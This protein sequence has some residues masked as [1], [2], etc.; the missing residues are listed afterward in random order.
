MRNDLGTVGAFRKADLRAAVN[1]MD[2]W[3][4]GNAA[5]INQAIPQPARSA[6]T[7]RQ[8]SLLLTAVVRARLRAGA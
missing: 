8:K 2:A 4:D 1:A 7:A 5:A 3:M 6:M